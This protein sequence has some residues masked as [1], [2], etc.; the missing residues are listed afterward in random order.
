M[1][2]HF[3]FSQYSNNSI[4]FAYVNE[5]KSLRKKNEKVLGKMKNELENLIM[6]EYI[7]HKSKAYSH[8]TQVP[9]LLSR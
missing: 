4:Q 6:D 2:G 8:C 5:F 3:D 9:V 7:G 1:N